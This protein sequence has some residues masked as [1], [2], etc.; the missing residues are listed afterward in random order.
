MASVKN[1][2]S[3][4]TG[5]LFVNAKLANI[6][7]KVY[8]EKISEEKTKSLLKKY[9]KPESCNKMRVPQCNPEI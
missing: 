4:K 5:N 9:Q 1:L 7:E 8:M 2:F 6:L 3:G